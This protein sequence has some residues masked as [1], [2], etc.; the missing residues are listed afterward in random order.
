M[1]LELAVVS[2][3]CVLLVLTPLPVYWKARSWTMVGLIGWMVAI[4]I[5]Q[6]I[7]YIAWADNV[8]VKHVVWCD[9]S[10]HL[11]LSHLQ[12]WLI[13]T[14]NQARLGRQRCRPSAANLPLSLPRHHCVP[15]DADLL[16]PT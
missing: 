4:N 11:L 1:R 6:G 5:I 12:P 2:F 3:V 13:I 16:Y 9:I 10:R 14:S 7:N 15:W 8:E